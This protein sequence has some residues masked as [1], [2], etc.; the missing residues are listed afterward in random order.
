MDRPQKKKNGRCSEVAFVNLENGTK[1]GE[2]NSHFSTT[3][4]NFTM[5]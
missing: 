5:L 4:E 3:L 2:F 1:N